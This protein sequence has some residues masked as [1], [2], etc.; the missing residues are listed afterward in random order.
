MPD[1]LRKARE[2]GERDMADRAAEGTA[3]TSTDRPEG[4]GTVVV[5][6]DAG[7]GRVLVLDPDGHREAWG[8]TVLT[9]PGVKVVE[10]RAE[11]AKWV[12][13]V[14]CREL[15]RSYPIPVEDGWA[16]CKGCAASWGFPSAWLVAGAT[17]ATCPCGP[18]SAVAVGLDDAHRRGLVLNA[19][20]LAVPPASTGYVGGGP[21]I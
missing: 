6:L 4:G 10:L 16:L 1:R 12:C 11:G 3:D 5:S 14:C 17:A 19:G 13:D 2:A 7:G 21:R 18:C 15:D 9:Q 20:R 8:S